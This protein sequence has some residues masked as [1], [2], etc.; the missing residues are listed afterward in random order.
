MAKCANQGGL[1]SPLLVHWFY[2]G[3]FGSILSPCTHC[4]CFCEFGLPKKYT[5]FDVYLQG[6]QFDSSY[7]TSREARSKQIHTWQ[8][9][10][11]IPLFE[12]HNK[13]HFMEF[14]SNIKVPCPKMMG[15]TKI[16]PWVSNQLAYTSIQAPKKSR[17]FIFW[18]E[19]PWSNRTVGGQI[20]LEI[21]PILSLFLDQLLKGEFPAHTTPLNLEILAFQQDLLQV[22]WRSFAR[23]NQALNPSY[24]NRP[25]GS[26]CTRLCK[27]NY[28]SLKWI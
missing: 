15:P 14:Y 2:L 13:R 6:Y 8:G 21:C 16:K 1:S 27:L 24:T 25:A 23:S 17:T 20:R 3:Y 11:W 22:V 4:I 19:T 12:F 9:P 5:S 18:L 26:E 7:S 10:S 28:Q